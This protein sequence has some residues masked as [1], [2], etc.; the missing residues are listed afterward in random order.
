MSTRL[1]LIVPCFPKLSE[2]F[3]VS[4]FLGLL[5]RGWDVHVVCSVSEKAQYRHFPNLENHPE[6]RRRIKVAWPHRPRWLAGLLMPFAF[7]HCFWSNPVGTWRYLCRGARRFGWGVLRQLYL[8]ARIVA[9]SPDLVHFEFGALAVDRM[10][11]KELLSMRI[12]VSFRGHDLHFVGLENSDHY[13]EVWEYVDGVHCLGSALWDRARQ[14]GSPASVPHALISPAVDCDYF[15]AP[16]RQRFDPAGNDQNPLRI[17][18]VGRLVWSKGYEY[19]IH[20]LWSLREM[21]V[22]FECRV[23]GGG[24]SQEAVAFCRHQMGLDNRVRFLGDQSREVV[25]EQM[26]WAD[27][28]LHSAVEEGFCNAV[29]EAQAMGLPV[30]CSDA[31]GLPEN[32]ADGETGF[33]VPRRDAQA[34]AEKLAVLSRD[35]VLRQKIGEA[36]RRRV[37]DRFQLGDQI[38]AFDHLYETVLSNNSPGA[39]ESPH[40]SF[41]EHAR[42]RESVVRKRSENS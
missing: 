6:A 3:I 25:H 11:L 21:G 29:I 5:E 35:A 33:V 30:V 36:G 22:S 27:V 34:L 37:L 41:Q 16:A 18:M 12:V 9:L 42:G 8:D 32:V 23:I 13:S 10:H 14:R 24:K 26:V 17:L 20:A 15:R 7:L 40:S 4:K 2:T 38:N 1:V 28:F 19:A 31:G 39:N